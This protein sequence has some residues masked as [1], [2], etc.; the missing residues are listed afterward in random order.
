MTR[1]VISLLKAVKSLVQEERFNVVQREGGTSNDMQSKE[2][3]STSEQQDNFSDWGNYKTVE[4]CPK[5][6]PRELIPSEIHSEAG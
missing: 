4:D 5:K 6:Y 3:N 1:K 2:R